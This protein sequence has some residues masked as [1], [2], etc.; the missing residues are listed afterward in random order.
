M[1]G[2]FGKTVFRYLFSSD[3]LL[4]LAERI[5]NSLIDWGFS[6][7]SVSIETTAYE[8]YARENSNHPLNIVFLSRFARNKGAL[9]TIRTVEILVKEYPK[10]KLYMVGE[11]ELSDD[12]QAYVRGH[13]LSGNI[14][15]TGWLDGE[16]KYELLSRCGVM[17]FP[18][19][20]GEG[21]PVS[22]LEGMGAGLAIVSR[23]VGGLP[24]IISDGENGYLADSLDI[25]EF[26]EHM[27]KLFKN[28]ML[29]EDISR[30]NKAVA[31]QK[32]E[33]KNVVKRL[34]NIYLEV[35]Q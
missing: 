2:R 29:W 16:A 34:E 7:D 32:F 30:K 25:N 14:E 27:R 24:D 18:S 28:R 33:I 26:A 5:R 19:S 20:Y 21:L 22:V 8:E 23:P 15:F 4:V 6:P 12:L 1:T 11:G 10:I 17:L 31:K 35:A 13:N 3:R 9:E